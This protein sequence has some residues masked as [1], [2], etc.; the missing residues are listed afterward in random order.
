MTQLNLFSEAKDTVAEEVKII[1]AESSG[2]KMMNSVYRL[3]GS[4]K[5]TASSGP[6]RANDNE[7]TDDALKSRE[8]REKIKEL[9][10]KEVE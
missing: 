1:S 9:R 5:M 2:N 7:V 8:S 4:I 3:D 6:P 10:T